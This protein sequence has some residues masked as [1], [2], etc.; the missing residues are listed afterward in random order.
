MISEWAV[1]R[2]ITCTSKLTSTLLCCYRGRKGCILLSNCLPTKQCLGQRFKA[3]LLLPICLCVQESMLLAWTFHTW[4]HND[5]YSISC[6][7]Q[8]LPSCAEGFP[9]HTNDEPVVY[10]RNYVGRKKVSGLTLV[11]ARAHCILF[12]FLDVHGIEGLQIPTG[13]APIRVD[14]FVAFKKLPHLLGS[15]L[16]VGVHWSWK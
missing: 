13:V 16:R 10:T 8:Q 5:W 6:K 3:S 1:C 14:H 4:I 9:Q 11:T 12:I 15:E 7:V 2:F